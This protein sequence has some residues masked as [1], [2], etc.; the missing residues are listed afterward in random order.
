[1]NGLL[2]KILKKEK[3]INVEFCQNNIDQFLE[4]ES[5]RLFQAFIN[6][7]HVSMREYTCLSHCE[8]CKEKPYAKVNGDIISAESSKDLLR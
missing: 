2:K 7:K 1:M 6:Q 3:K 4:E 8:L 5:L